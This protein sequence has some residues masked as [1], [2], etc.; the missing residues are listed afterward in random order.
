MSATVI[1]SPLKAKG[2]VVYHQG[3]R[4]HGVVV[5]AMD[6]C[7]P[8]IRT[9]LKEKLHPGSTVLVRIN[10]GDGKLASITE[11]HASRTGEVTISAKYSKKK[12]ATQPKAEQPAKAKAKST[13]AKAK[14][15]K[16]KGGKKKQ[17]AGLKK[18][19]AFMAEK[20]AAGKT[21][22]QALALWKKETPSE[23]PAK[24]PKA[25]S[26]KGKGKGKGKSA[27]NVFVAEVIKS[28]RAKNISEAAK[29]WKKEKPAGQ[30]K[31]KAAKAKSTKAK[32]PK[33]AK[34]KKSTKGEAGNTQPKT[35][36]TKAAYVERVSGAKVKQG[37]PADQAKR[38]AQAEWENAHTKKDQA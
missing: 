20:K 13:K 30:A 11:Y 35:K 32:Q 4:Q 8:V 9:L 15:P 28:G 38:I 23:T 5:D 21:H 10:S 16:A 25:K 36:E 3:Q 33:A 17:S 24:Q 26:T 7:E 29:L 1:V 27:Y 18:Y 34:A 14:Q 2:W 22:T 6:K 19:Q 37:Y 12:G 31:P